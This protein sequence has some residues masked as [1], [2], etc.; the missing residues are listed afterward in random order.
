MKPF[1]IEIQN[2]W[3]WADKLD[4]LDTILVQS[5]FSIIQSLFLQKTK[6]DVNLGLGFEFEFEPQ[7]IRDVA[8]VCP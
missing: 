2:L 4:K 8:F 6:H 3:A 5:I 7:K 1:F